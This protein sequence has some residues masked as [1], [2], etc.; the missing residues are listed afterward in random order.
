MKLKDVKSCFD[1]VVSYN[2]ADYILTECILWQDE[3]N[4]FK[5]SLTLED[6]QRRQ[7]RVPI[8]KVVKK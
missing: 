2:G 8:E 5:Y 1:Q 6:R 4:N 3:N 7:Y